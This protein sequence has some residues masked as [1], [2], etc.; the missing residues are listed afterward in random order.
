MGVGPLDGLGPPGAGPLV[1]FEPPGEG[2]LEGLGPPGEGPLDGLGP[3]VVGLLGV[4]L[5]GG[6]PDE[7][8]LPVPAVG[9]TPG[10]LGLEV[11]G[12]TIPCVR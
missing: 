8:L 4:G 3:G 2:P 5:L 10:L 6:L 1:G 9:P 12:I 11:P 7:G